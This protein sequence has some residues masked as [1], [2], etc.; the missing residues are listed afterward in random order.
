MVKHELPSLA[1]KNRV[2][3]RFISRL[4]SAS[5]FVVSGHR[6]PDADCLATML[7][8]AL[9]ARKL[10]KPVTIVIDG[11][12]SPNV[13]FLVKI[14]EY[15][16]IEINGIWSADADTVVICDTAKPDLLPANPDFRELLESPRTV[17]FEIDHHLGS[18]SEFIADPANALVDRASSS[19]SLLARLVF[20]L[21]RRGTVDDLLS[22]NMVVSLLIGMMS[23][24][25]MGK[26]QPSHS[27]ARLYKRGVVILSE[28]LEKTTFS[29]DKIDTIQALY[30]EMVRLTNEEQR[31]D[32]YFATR[33]KQRGAVAWAALDPDESDRLVTE[34]GDSNVR[35]SARRITDRMTEVSGKIGM[36]TYV[37][38]TDIVQCRM[39]REYGYRDVDLRQVIDAVG[40]DDGGGHPGAIAFRFPAD[41]IA[42]YQ[43]FVHDLV[44]LANELTADS[45]S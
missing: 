2:Y 27:E 24:T 4:E 7:G 44:E 28:L 17:V 26:V 37:D 34:F 23:D 45:N 11:S 33:T 5:G 16:R 15:N 31:I 18:D 8:A 35:S 39:R 25:Q 36:V 12:I 13:E 6:N 19:G 38:G 22:R 14:A 20:K 43:R 41:D 42:D 1:A 10:H 32:E 29:P 3:E 9:L 21:Y 30:A 40:T